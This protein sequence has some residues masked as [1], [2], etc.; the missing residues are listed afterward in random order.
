MGVVKGTHI[1][2][3]ECIYVVSVKNITSNSVASILSVWLN[4]SARLFV[5]MRMVSNQL[6]N[7]LQKYF[8]FSGQFVRKHPWFILAPVSYVINS[9]TP[10]LDSCFLTN[11]SYMYYFIIICSPGFVALPDINT[12]GEGKSLLHYSSDSSWHQRVFMLQIMCND[13]DIF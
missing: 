1:G 12:N 7:F 9:W 10:P 8:S 4:I 6:D 11:Y 3:Y 2:L 5:R 13:N